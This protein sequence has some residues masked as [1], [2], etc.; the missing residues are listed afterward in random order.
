MCLLFANH[1]LLF[2]S[3][4]SPCLLPPTHLAPP[5]P[6][7]CVMFSAEHPS[8]WGIPAGGSWKSRCQMVTPPAV[9]HELIHGSC[10][11]AS[12]RVCVSDCWG[13]CLTLSPCQEDRC[14]TLA[15]EHT[16]YLWILGSTL[17]FRLSKVWSF[18][19]T[20]ALFFLWFLGNFN[21]LP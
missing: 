11:L 15:K 3:L 12:A 17:I 14:L 20:N 21:T 4:L 16:L 8:H 6:A 10:P 13:C 7:C 18:I 19:R 5:L 9:S 2:L 1:S